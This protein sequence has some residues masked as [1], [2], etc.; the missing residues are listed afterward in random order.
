MRRRCGA[1]H[2]VSHDYE[3]CRQQLLA[4]H[5]PHP[6]VVAAIDENHLRHHR[7]TSLNYFGWDTS[8]GG[9][10]YQ[11]WGPVCIVTIVL[12]YHHISTAAVQQPH[13]RQTELASGAHIIALSF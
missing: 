7:A 13:G 6:R 11:E 1:P 4:R 9:R 10:G 12:M 5:R 2:R 8:A 3:D